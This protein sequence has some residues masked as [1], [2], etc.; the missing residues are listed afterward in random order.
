MGNVPLVPATGRFKSGGASLRD[1][2][3]SRLQL[4]SGGRR[5]HG[6]ETYV[7]P[8]QATG[9]AGGT[10]RGSYLGNSGG[11]PWPEISEHNPTNFLARIR[12]VTDFMLELVFGG[13][14]RLLETSA[15]NSE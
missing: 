2:N 3:V 1:Q 14:G 4:F 10:K 7:F 15:I 9:R 11:S 13:F 6:S 5:Q 8:A 12:Q